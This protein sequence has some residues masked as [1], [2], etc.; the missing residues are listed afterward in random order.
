MAGAVAAT[1]CLFI[2]PHFKIVHSH[3]STIWPVSH[4]I[5]IFIFTF[6]RG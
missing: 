5:I 4:T 6:G 2:G 1:V 3:K